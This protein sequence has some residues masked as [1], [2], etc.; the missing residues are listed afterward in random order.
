[1]SNIYFDPTL[2]PPLF[3][4]PHSSSQI[5]H[6]ISSLQSPSASFRSPDSPI[7]S[8]I[9]VFPD[10]T[11]INYH[12]LGISLCFLPSHPA[13]E[14]IN[15]S[16]RLLDFVDIYNPPVLPS[17][18]PPT[19]W[20]RRRKVAGED[21]SQP[22]FPIIFHFPTRTESLPS[23]KPGEELQLVERPEEVRVG[24]G[25]NG[26]DFVRA[27]GEPARK[28]GGEGWIPIFM[29]WRN[30]ELVIPA[31]SRQHVDDC[32]GARVETVVLSMM[33]ELRDPGPELVMTDEQKRKGM[34]G[35]WDQAAEWAWASLK[36]FKPEN[37][38]SKV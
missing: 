4:L 32:S 17:V 33:V 2:I 9:S 20:R 15:S 27:F 10:C 14:D 18:R 5:Q 12:C 11:Y 23:P 31:C 8:E 22:V 28:G 21:Y 30:V 3:N 6:Y 37:E 26:R 35:I 29:E 1:M 38:A 19:T 36:L 16:D 34:G 13:K 24:P 7:Q 25:T